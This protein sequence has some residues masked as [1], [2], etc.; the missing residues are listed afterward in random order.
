[1][2]FFVCKGWSLL[3]LLFVL[4][5]VLELFVLLLVWDVVDVIVGGV[6]MVGG[7]LEMDCLKKKCF[8]ECGDI[9]CEVGFDLMCMVLVFV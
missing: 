2:E 4:E 8:F 3:F 5:E 6:E 7:E 9:E 1:M